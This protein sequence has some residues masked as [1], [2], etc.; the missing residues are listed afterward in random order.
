MR[1]TPIQQ[2]IAS[3]LGCHPCMRIWR[4]NTGMGYPVSQVKAGKR[5]LLS[6]NVK[7][8]IDALTHM[9]PIRFGVP[10]A[11]D[12]SGIAEGGQR[13]ELEVK[14]ESGQQKEQQQAWEAMITKFG[15]EYRLFYSAQEAIAWAEAKWPGWTWT[16]SRGHG[17][18]VET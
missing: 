4:Q 12:I 10:G 2:D 13:L 11:G 8:A 9:Q 18:W 1:E 6:G 14:S 15:G 7:S 5:L 17:R 16:P 3:V